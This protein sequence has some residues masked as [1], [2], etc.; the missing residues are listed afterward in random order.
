MSG[1]TQM[2]SFVRFGLA[3]LGLAIV[4]LGIGAYVGG[5]SGADERPPATTSL[6]AT[7]CT[8]PPPGVSVADWC[9]GG[10]GN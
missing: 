3:S 5:V 7:S 8:S 9:P 2:K 4:G 10:T 6:Q 1:M